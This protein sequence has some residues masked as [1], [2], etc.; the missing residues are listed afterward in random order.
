[1]DMTDRRREVAELLVRG[2]SRKEIATE[3]GIVERTVKSHIDNL[4]R[5]LGV[6]HS[7]QVPWAYQQKTTTS[8][9]ETE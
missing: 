6:S 8:G 9:G 4:R 1:M 2:L 3:L 5:D 7:R